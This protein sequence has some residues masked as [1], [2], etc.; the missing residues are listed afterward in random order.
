MTHDGSD[1]DRLAARWLT[2]RTV[3]KAGALG[4]TA[5]GAATAPRWPLLGGGT[6]A[7]RQVKTLAER[8]DQSD[9][10]FER[11]ERRG[12]ILAERAGRRVLVA[13]RGAGGNQQY[14]S[15]SIALDFPLTHLGLHWDARSGGGR[16]QVS[17]RVSGDGATWG[18]WLTPALDAAAGEAPNGD[19]FGAL[20]SVEGARF[21]QYRVALDGSGGAVEVNR[22]SLT[23]LNSVDGERVVARVAAPGASAAAPKPALVT[24]AAWGA[25][26][27]YRY[28]GGTE[29]WPREYARWRKVVF[30]HT[31]TAN[32]YADA[33]AQVR[34]I[35]YYH[36]VTQGWGDI[37]YHALIGNDGRI[38]EGR[39]GWEGDPVSLDLI[40]G[41]VYRCNVGTMGFS[42]IGDFS[43]T[44][45]PEAM[46]D[47]GARIA[48]WACA[49]RAI[50]PQGSGSFTRSDGTVTTVANIPGHRHIA[51]PASPTSCPGDT[52]S[53]QLP[54]FRQRVATIVATNAAT[55]TP[56]RTPT[57]I[58][59]A[60]A[61]ATVVATATRTPTKPPTKP[62]TA[63][64]T[65]TRQPIATR[66]PTKPPAA[67]TTPT[68]QATA[69][70]PAQP[71]PTATTRPPT[72]TPVPTQP[73]PPPTATAALASYRIAG[74]GRSANSGSSYAVFDTNEATFWTSTPAATPPTSAYVYVDLG[75]IKPIGAIQWVFGAEGLAP[76]VRLQVSNDRVTWTNLTASPFAGGPVGQWREIRPAL[77]ARYVRWYFGNP[78]GIAQIGGLAEVKVW[79]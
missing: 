10:A 51:S 34:S 13:D 75:A 19:A 57:R 50:D 71:S 14:V 30:H 36:A 18:D 70:T 53:S 38:Y 15:E 22:V 31:A 2:R 8:V 37:G 28:S 26:E 35:Y 6:V 60:T 55:A 78:P 56:T 64:R 39:K 69:T 62:P 17:A 68:R 43:S 11:G 16:V 45:I 24:R 74:S 3:L 40:A 5:L 7:A 42:M 1:G 46:L 77:S 48:A 65:P 23:G 58:A 4:A 66:T 32:G 72:G 49:A 9:R 79:P 52:G 67:T 73:P 20:L 33:A 61:T 12:A 54:N 25:Y 29:L 47:A 21:V 27:G 76:E 59:T 41:H 44:A 63:T